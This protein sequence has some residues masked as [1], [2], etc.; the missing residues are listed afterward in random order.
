MTSSQQWAALARQWLALSSRQAARAMREREQEAARRRREWRPDAS[1]RGTRAD[2]DAAAELERVRWATEPETAAGPTEEEIE[3][4]REALAREVAL[5]RAR[6]RARRE[7]EGRP[8]GDP[9]A[10]EPRGQ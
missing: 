9:A 6:E 10:H 3:A 1:W 8:G 7:R 5:A 2:G 4:A